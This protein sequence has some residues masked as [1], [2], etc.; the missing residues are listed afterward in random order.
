[1]LPVAIVCGNTYVMK[2]SE[3]VPNTCVKLVEMLREAGAPDGVVNVI[4]GTHEAVN[5]ICDHPDIK[6][7]SFIGSDSAVR[8]SQRAINLNSIDPVLAEHFSLSS[9]FS[10][11]KN[12][13]TVK[14][15]I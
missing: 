11:G 1:M 14:E 4:H 13:S 15:M 2:P 7:I 8:Q 12:V 3:R 6:A 9:I 10:C 5:F